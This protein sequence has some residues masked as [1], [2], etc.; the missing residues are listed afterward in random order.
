MYCNY[1][2]HFS[3]CGPPLLLPQIV[4]DYNVNVCPKGFFD[5]LPTW[6]ILLVGDVNGLRMNFDIKKKCGF[7]LSE[8][9]KKT[10][11]NKTGEGM[12]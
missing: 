3:P 2:T 6:S 9:L 4:E 8:Y 10:R 11:I 7:N 1:T 5:L 12:K